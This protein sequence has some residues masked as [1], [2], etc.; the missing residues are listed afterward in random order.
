[1]NIPRYNRRFSLLLL[2]LVVLLTGCDFIR[3]HFK[4]EKVFLGAYITLPKQEGDKVTWRFMDLPD[5]SRITHFL[6]SDTAQEVSFKPDVPGKYDV[7]VTVVRNGKEEEETFY[8]TVELPENGEP[9]VAEVPEHLKAFM[10]AE[11]TRTETTKQETSAAVVPKADL[12]AHPYLAK[13]VKKKATKPR[14][15]AVVKK[16]RK[17][18]SRVKRKAATRAMVDGL[19]AGTG[20]TIQLSA[21]PTLAEAQ[22]AARELKERYGLDTYVQR[23][24]IKQQDKVYFRVRVGHF[25]SFKAAREYARELQ[26]LTSLPAWVDFVRQE[27]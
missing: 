5:T 3:S 12:K 2:A 23:V 7:A 18:I 19:R 20:Y 26:D 27:M 13:L 4:R 8:F 21:W 16:R 6:P 10:K 17:R 22:Q 25:D 24:F 9:V 11:T 1:M 14:Q 15:K